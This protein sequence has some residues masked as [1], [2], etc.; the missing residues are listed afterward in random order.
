[1]IISGNTA[2]KRVIKLNIVPA[3]MSEQLFLCLT[4]RNAAL[5][6]HILDRHLK[7]T[8]DDVRNLHKHAKTRLPVQTSRPYTPHSLT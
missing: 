7:H 4:I 6:E 3:R 1:M 8:L 2:Y 5:T